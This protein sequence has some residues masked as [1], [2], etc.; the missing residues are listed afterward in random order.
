MAT[1]KAVLNK[2]YKSKD[3]TYPIV[4]RVID[5]T[6]QKL[7]NTGYKVKEGQFKN[8]EATKHPDAA[9]INSD[10]SDLLTPAKRYISECRKKNRHIEFDEIFKKQSDSNFLQYLSE[11]S[12]FYKDRNQV[13]MSKRLLHFIEELKKVGVKYV[14]DIDIKTLERYDIYLIKKDIKPNTRKKK[15][16]D[17]GRFAP[18]FKQYKINSTPVKKEKLT[19]A[20]IT[21]IEKATLTGLVDDARNLFLLSYYCKGMRFENCVLL[22]PKKQINNG[23]VFIT[24]NKGKKHLS[25]LLHERLKNILSS[26][27]LPY[28]TRDK[29]NSVNVVVNRN[30]KIVAGIAGIK[31]NLSMHIARHTLAFHLKRMKKEIVVIQDVLGHSRSNTTE[32][33]VKSIDDEI[34]DIEMHDLYG[35]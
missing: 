16:K 29:I 18:I 28:C 4:I 35:D 32:A 25:I 12:Q 30:L 10:I 31:I 8:G 33:Y 5:G 1:V 15:F 22:D 34:L 6:S 21:A 20:E 23:R 2:R 14:E 17:L 27:Q 7:H 24:T 26:L 3:G 11:R 13:V 9:I 19:T